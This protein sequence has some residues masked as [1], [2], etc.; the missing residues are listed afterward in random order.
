MLF[1]VSTLRLIPLVRERSELPD[2]QSIMPRV[3]SWSDGSLFR[4]ITHRVVTATVIGAKAYFF[5]AS[6][7]GAIGM[8]LERLDPAVSAR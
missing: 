4:V 3:F 7:A 6:G 5:E 1:E 8:P 2:D